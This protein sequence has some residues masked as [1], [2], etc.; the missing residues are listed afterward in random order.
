VRALVAIALRDAAHADSA[1]PA[2]DLTYA[3]LPPQRRPLHGRERQET[4]LSD[5]GYSPANLAGRP[6][7][8]AVV[9]ASVE[10]WDGFSG[11]RAA[12]APDL[13][14]DGALLSHRGSIRTRSPPTRS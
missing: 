8:V 3:P 9:G 11:D 10:D 1:R 4:R 7:T 5:A 2:H 14:G 6:K 13:P 12:L